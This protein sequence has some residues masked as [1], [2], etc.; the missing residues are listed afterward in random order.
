[1]AGSSLVRRQPVPPGVQVAP[2]TARTALPRLRG[3]RRRAGTRPY[4]SRPGRRFLAPRIGPMSAT[5]ASGVLDLFVE[6]AAIPSPSGEEGP[7]AKVI[8]AYLGDLGLAVEDD[9]AG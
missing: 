4:R 3:R 8:R 7:V 5:W 1:A 2:H 9:E 6:L